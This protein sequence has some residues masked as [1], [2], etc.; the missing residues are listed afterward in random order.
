MVSIVVALA[1]Q[2]LLDRLPTIDALWEPTWLAVRVWCEA[3][4][5]LT[6]IFKMW[7]GFV[8]G[9]ATSER[10]PRPADLIGPIGILVFVDAQIAS[11]DVE[12]ILRWLY[13]LG[14]GS[15][16]AAAFIAGQRLRFDEQRRLERGS[17]ASSGRMRVFTSLP[18]PATVE[19]WIGAI[20]LVFALLHQTIEFREPGQLAICAVL[21]VVEAASAVGPVMAW[22][23]LRR[24]ED[25]LLEAGALPG[26]ADERE[27]H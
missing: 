1:L 21:L 24:S 16:A 6:I 9:A 8:L 12:H 22:R 5:A 17:V 19:T 2:E 25:A 27:P 13:I 7:S 4:I 3:L 18:D 14:V 20:A 23:I 11:I 26:A 10:V 15:L